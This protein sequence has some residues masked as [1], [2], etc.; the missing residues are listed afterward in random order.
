MIESIKFS[1]E[2]DKELKLICE[3]TVKDKLDNE[4]YKYENKQ[5]IVNSITDE[6]IKKLDESKWIY[7]TICTCTLVEKGYAKLWF[8]SSCLWSNKDDGSF[9]FTYTDND[10]VNCF[11]CLYMILP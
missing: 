3:D 7:K 1:K 9:T 11:I 5:D 8:S 2:L 4:K 6:V 10:Y